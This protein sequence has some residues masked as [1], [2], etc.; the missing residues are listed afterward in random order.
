M[1]SYWPC[2]PSNGR[3]GRCKSKSHLC[4][5]LIEKNDQSFSAIDCR[6]AALGVDR[7]AQIG[8]DRVPISAP[9]E[10]NDKIEHWGAR[11]VDLTPK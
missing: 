3:L 10:T 1:F 11:W 5:L 8:Q 6:L 2:G 9:I 4:N 7:A